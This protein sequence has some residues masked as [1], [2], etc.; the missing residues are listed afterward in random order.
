[1]SEFIEASAVRNEQGHYQLEWALKQPSPVDVYVGDSAD[2][3]HRWVAKTD[4]T[5]LEFECDSADKRLHFLLKTNKAVFPL[6]ERRIAFA[7]TSNFRDF[8]GYNTVDGGM[9]KWGSLYRSGKLSALTDSDIQRIEHL[10][11]SR[12]FDFRR[13]EEAQLHPTVDQLARQS[14]IERLIIGKGSARSFNQLIRERGLSESEVIAGVRD[15]YRDLAVEHVNAYRI[16][17]NYLLTNSAPMLMHCTAGK[18]RTGVGAALILLALGVDRDTVI[19]DYLLTSQY[20]PSDTEMAEM[21][22]VFGSRPELWDTL[23]L[24]LS[25]QPEFIQV[26]FEIID[27][28]FGSEEN[29]FQS[30]FELSERELATLREN[31]LV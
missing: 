10:G 21:N 6:S 27:S 5:A 2:G 15:I 31:W 29:Y 7:G 4:G 3:E 26:L 11:I 16:I 25:V 23:N 18:D 19:Q 13:E 14:F 20:Y 8:G 1:M 9:V 17:F 24:L 12:I 30:L 22:K 28:E